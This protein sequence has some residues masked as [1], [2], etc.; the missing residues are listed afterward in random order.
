MKDLTPKAACLSIYSSALDITTRLIFVLR[1]ELLR[2]GR[3]FADFGFF[4]ALA[5]FLRWRQGRTTR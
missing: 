3:Q 1:R 2:G 4:G 5:E